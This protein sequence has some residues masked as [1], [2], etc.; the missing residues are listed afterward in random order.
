MNETRQ[1]GSGPVQKRRGNSEEDPY[2]TEA[3]PTNGASRNGQQGSPR[4]NPHLLDVWTVLDILARR[5]GWVVMG[6]LVSAAAFFVLAEWAIK[7]KYTATAQMLRY[8]TPAASEFLRNTPITVETFVGLIR[9]PDLLQQVG[10]A[11]EPPIPPERLVKMIKIDPEPDSDMI[12]IQ[13]AARSQDQAVHILNLY[14]EKIVEFT[15]N[16]QAKQAAT[17]A[18]DY[19]KQQVAEMGREIE[20][21]HQQFRALPAGGAVTGKLAQISGDLSMLGTSLAASTRPSIVVSKLAE[22]LQTAL[23]ELSE[24]T[25]KYTDIHPSVMAK[26]EQIDALKNQLSQSATNSAGLPPGAA[27]VALPSG[28]TMAEPDYDIIRMRLLS[29]EDGRVQ[30]ASRLREAQMFAENPPGI[31]R[32]FAPATLQTTESNLRWIKIPAVGIFGGLLGMAAGLALIGLLELTDR[33]L[34]TAEDLHRVTRLPVLTSLGDLH[35]MKPE[36][37]SRWAFRTWTMLQGRLSRS[38]NHGLICGITSSTSGEGRSTWIS[39]LAEAASLAG[40]R[41]LT[42][43]TRQNPGTQPASGDPEFDP[44]TEGPDMNT[45]NSPS[46]ALTGNVL[47]SPMKV[48]EQLTG[49]NSPPVVHIPLPG[50]VWNL[51]RRKQ[52]QEALGHWQDIDNLVILVE[53]PPAE[54]SEAVLLGQNLPNVVWLADSG[55]ADA[56]QTR[57]QIE[58]MRHARCNLVGAVLNREPGA[59]VRSRFPRWFAASAAAIGL[60]VNTAVAQTDT[61]PRNEAGTNGPVA[62]RAS[63]SVVD[64]SQRAD[65]QKRLTLGPGDVLTL[66]LYGAPELARTEVAVG[67]DGRISY[68]EAQ[69]VMAEGRTVDELRGALD[70]ELGKFRRAPRTLVTP[71][72]FKSK[73]YF[74][75]GKVMSKGVYTLD[76][77][78]T[79]LEAIARA[80][81]F[82]NGLV[83][84]NVIDLADMSRSFLMRGGKRFALNFEKLFQ[85]GDLSQNIPIEPGDYLYFPSTNV[86]EVYVVGEV[87]LPGPVTF[88]QDMSVVQAITER[89]GYTERAYKG[90]VLVVRGSL[91]N[92]E[93]YAVDTMGVIKGEHIDF[94]LRAK[95]IVYV[96]SRP[97][98]RVEELADLA[99]TAFIQSMITTWVGVDVVKPIN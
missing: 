92:P 85:E 51:E 57:T 87:R 68:L 5:W 2:I 67:P 58:T 49:P 11:V 71:I 13:F 80:R 33:R 69:D 35:R 89:G 36:D 34:K 26:R 27:T 47:N 54:V 42:I 10:S 3:H 44:F 86:K 12:K 28:V 46:S 53:L 83:D 19:L 22:R 18:N 23:N 79:V 94:K 29:L 98:I 32:L 37:R 64:P 78:I 82:E 4:Q 75:L 81:G 60:L 62:R 1:S 30:L 40:F 59:S 20:G 65:W 95:D 9:S 99:A 48:T 55:A 25:L 61:L 7:P 93:T 84:R 77:P 97:F 6:F 50:W 16:L 41:V 63:F 17:V 56:G 8:E 24:L 91:N 74:V 43:A 72:T 39:L 66:G 21:L 96:N 70:Q 31:V 14:C 90:R 38:A 15:R 52:W 45:P 73:K 76:R 88:R